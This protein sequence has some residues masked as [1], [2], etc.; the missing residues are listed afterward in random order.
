MTRQK[1]FAPQSHGNA[2]VPVKPTGLLK[3]ARGQRASRAVQ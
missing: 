3:R 1:A 2:G